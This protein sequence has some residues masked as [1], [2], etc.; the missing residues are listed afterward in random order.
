ML[1][2]PMALATAAGVDDVRGV[3]ADVLGVPRDGDLVR[4]TLR[5]LV[6]DVDHPVTA[7]TYGE[8]LGRPAAARVVLSVENK[9]DEL[10]YREGRRRLA[11]VAADLAGRL[12]A[13]A[14]LTFQLDRVVMRRTGGELVLYS[15]FP[16]WADPD[17]RASITAPVR[18]TDEPGDL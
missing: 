8:L 5:G 6:A 4:G 13:E 9:T 7:A 18:V 15:W 11:V 16:E 2:F 14:C 17:V 12:D 3:L 1:D 10:A